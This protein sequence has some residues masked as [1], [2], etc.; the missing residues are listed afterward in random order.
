[1]HKGNT[2]RESM[3]IIKLS[4]NDFQQNIIKHYKYY[5]YIITMIDYLIIK[6]YNKIIYPIYKN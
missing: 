5:I 4:K 1:M 6:Y 2:R 3:M